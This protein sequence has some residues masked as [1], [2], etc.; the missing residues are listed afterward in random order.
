LREFTFRIRVRMDDGTLR[1]FTGFR[2]QHN[3]A[4]GPHKGGLRFHRPRHW[5]PCR[6]VH[7]DDLE[8]RRRRYPAGG[9]KGG[10]IVDPA[11]LSI[12]EKERLCRGWIQQMW[13]NIGPRQDGAGSGCLHHATDDELDDG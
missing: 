5:T 8:V 13:K 2:V 7:V 10:V 3:D 1:V 11:T 9:G 12:D 6:S 4:R